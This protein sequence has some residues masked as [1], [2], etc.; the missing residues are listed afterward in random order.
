MISWNEA[1]GNSEHLKPRYA[2]ILIPPFL[3]EEIVGYPGGVA[4]YVREACTL[5][6]W[7]LE[8][9]KKGRTLYSV[10]NGTKLEYVS[11]ALY[12]IRKSVRERTKQS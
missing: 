11:P 4:G 1:L 7:V 12:A 6:S 10:G 3:K 8:E 5:Y 2:D 9:V